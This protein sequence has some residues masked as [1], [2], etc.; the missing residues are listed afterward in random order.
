MN[1]V[2]NMNSSDIHHKLLQE[3]YTAFPAA[4]KAASD[5]S[6]PLKVEQKSPSKTVSQSVQYDE[7]LHQV[8]EFFTDYGTQRVSIDG[9]LSNG[10]PVIMTYHDIGINHNACFSSFFNLMEQHDA[11]FKYFNVVHIDAPQHHYE[12]G[13]T[14]STA[15]A[16]SANSH[17][18]PSIFDDDSI[19][20]FDLLE[21]CTQIEEIRS[22][23]QIDKFVA[24]GVGAACNVWTYYAINYSHRLRGL[25]LINGLGSVASWREWIFDALLSAVGQ[26][27]QFL[28]DSFQSSLLTR[29]FPRTVAK[30]TYDYFLDEFERIHTASTIKYLRG[31][32]RRQEF[33]EEQ[34]SKIKTKTLVICGEFSRVKDETISFQRMMPRQ[35]TTFVLMPSS[36]FL[37]TESEPQ[38]LCSSIDLFM[39]SLGFTTISLQ[40]K[41]GKFD[42]EEENGIAEL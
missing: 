23:L 13:D 16:D 32:I 31:F 5:V 6:E 29:Y 14:T 1:I 38:K 4:P 40:R 9:D 11:K 21:L 41:Y 12:D 22:R 26:K 24:I 37:L 3:D 39:Q 19:E 20:A 34:L 33:T 17:G 7:N 36:G 30:E 15:T 28:I 25:I 35:Y 8:I 42:E 2:S 27:S 10:R 18:P